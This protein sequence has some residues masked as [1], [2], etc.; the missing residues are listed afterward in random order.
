MSAHKTL[1]PSIATLDDVVRRLGPRS[2]WD[3][4]VASVR[5]D[6]ARQRPT[7]MLAAADSAHLEKHPPYVA[8]N[9]FSCARSVLQAP[10]AAFE[11]TRT[12]GAPVQA[13]CG[14]PVFMYDNE[15]KRKPAPEKKVYVVYVRKG[16]VFD[17]DWVDADPGNRFYPVLHEQRF[18]K[19]ILGQP[20]NL[21]CE[22]REVHDKFDPSVGVH[23]QV[24]D[25]IFAYFA[26]DP[27]YAVR[28]NENLTV[29]RAMDGKR[30]VVG[31][32]IKNVQR[33]MTHLNP[34]VEASVKIHVWRLVALSVAM[35]AGNRPP[36]KEP[37]MVAL[38]R[39][40]ETDPMPQVEWRR[41]A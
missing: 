28:I 35:Q 29:F 16:Y 40:L 17:W 19:Q 34:G 13:Y 24:G 31:C 15:G 4:A 37:T 25:C 14:L 33:L 6:G 39:Q 32:K 27:S 9:L 5:E 23:S 20:M 2:T 41:A 21:G 22:R 26:K 3:D 18:T 36:V 7:I 38:S 11:G 8:H 10:K 12:D 30:P 1:K